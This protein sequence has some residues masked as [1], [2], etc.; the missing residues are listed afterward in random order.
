MEYLGRIV[1]HE[2]VKVDPRK[3][4]AIKEWKVPTTIKHL[5]GF[6]WL[7]GYYRKFAKN[8][9]RIVA[10]LTTLLKKEAFSWTLEATKAFEHLKEAMCLA[11]VLATL[12][13]TKPLLWNVM[14]QEMEL[15]LF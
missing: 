7:I 13:L 6:L 14:P 11:L 10:P 15:V 4:K 5:C 3:I 2:G 12:D 9:G 1:S 8:Y